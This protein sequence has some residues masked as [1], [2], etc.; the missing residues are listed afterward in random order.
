ME[1]FKDLSIFFGFRFEV[2]EDKP[3]GRFFCFSALLRW[4]FSCLGNLLHIFPFAFSLSL[5]ISIHSSLIFA[6]SLLHS[7]CPFLASFPS[8]LPSIHPPSEYSFRYSTT[9]IIFAHHFSSDTYVILEVCVP[10]SNVFLVVLPQILSRSNRFKHL[11]GLFHKTN[12]QKKK[13]TPPPH[14]TLSR[15]QR[16]H[17]QQKY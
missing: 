4:Y 3:S 14:H 5:S 1:P 15:L 7:L 13:P 9:A 17:Q 11:H 8:I 10:S 16:S 6:L 12:D 2:Q